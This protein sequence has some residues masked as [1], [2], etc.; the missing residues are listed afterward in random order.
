MVVSRVGGA[1]NRS[2]FVD[3][4]RPKYHRET[5]ERRPRKISLDKGATGSPE[6]KRGSKIRRKK[7]HSHEKK[8][9]PNS[10]QTSAASRPASAFKPS[11]SNEILGEEDEEDKF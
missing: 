9:R 11:L 8:E 10:T 2:N 3:T 6:E 4:P 5:K 1:L 7:S